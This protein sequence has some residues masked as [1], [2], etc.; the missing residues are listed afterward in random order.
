M[1][2]SNEMNDADRDDIIAFISESQGSGYDPQSERIT[3]LL[4][5]LGDE[6]GTGLAHASIAEKAALS[7]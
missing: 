1:K 6:I 5:Q 3:T 4:K 7:T 2:A